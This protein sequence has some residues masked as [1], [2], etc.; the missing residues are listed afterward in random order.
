MLTPETPMW[1]LRPEVAQRLLARLSSST[2]YSF[3]CYSVP[4]RHIHHVV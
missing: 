2:V 1:R 4:F 3:T